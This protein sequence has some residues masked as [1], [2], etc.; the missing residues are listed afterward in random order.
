MPDDVALAYRFARASLDRDPEAD[1]LR[2]EVVRRWGPRGLVSLA[3]A[4]TAARMF[5]TLKSALGRAKSC[6]SIRVAGELVRP[7]TAGAH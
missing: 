5:P 6:T 7:A 4:V 1:A 3:F 2:D